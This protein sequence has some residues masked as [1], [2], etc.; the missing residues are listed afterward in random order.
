MINK[1]VNRSK[2]K[3]SIFQNLPR[4]C[5]YCK[6]GKLE[7]IAYGLKSGVGVYKKRVSAEREI[8]VLIIT[9]DARAGKA[10][11]HT[12]DKNIPFYGCLRFFCLGLLVSS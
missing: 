5:L 11:S 12:W 1:P 4:K 10:N 7:K 2:E 9:I 3:V 6:I 8:D